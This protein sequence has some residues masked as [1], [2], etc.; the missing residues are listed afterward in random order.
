[1]DADG[2]VHA[3]NEGMVGLG[4][5]GAKARI[6]NV[7]V[8]KLADPVSVERGTTFSKS[9]AD[10]LKAPASGTWNLSSG[11]YSTTVAS[12]S[13]P[14]MVLS[15]IGVTGPTYSASIE[16]TFTTT[17]MG[18][19]V[20]DVYSV[21]SYKFVVIDATTNRLLIGHYAKRTGWIVDFAVKLATVAGDCA[22]AVSLQG[23]VVNVSVDGT[24]V[25]GYAYN[26]LVTDGRSG[27]IGV[28]GTTSFDSMSVK[29]TDPASSP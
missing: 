1:V 19:I 14:S 26:A 3:L 13:A 16:T 7:I 28:A 18:G 20:F 5:Q 25:G 29:S 4:A 23:N 17:A 10:A 21:D 24:G 9:P 27:L 2:F 12:T 8:Q 22:L 11:R 6:D 15:T